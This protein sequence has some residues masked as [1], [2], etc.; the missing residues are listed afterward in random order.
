MESRGL[1]GRA[2]ANTRGLAHYQHGTSGN[3]ANGKV[4]WN[5]E[6]L[7]TVGV[8]AYFTNKR[9]E[10]KWLRGGEGSTVSTPTSCQ[11]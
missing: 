8:Y 2:G 5:C 6:Q 1:L 10:L 11:D 9:P 4:K 7:T 3:Y